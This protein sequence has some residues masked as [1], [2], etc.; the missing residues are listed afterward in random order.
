MGFR[1]LMRTSSVVSL[2]CVAATLPAPAFAQQAA[3]RAQGAAADVEQLRAE[4]ADARAQIAAQNQKL[5]EQQRRL[6]LFE[7]RLQGLAQTT[8][9]IR[10]EALAAG[11]SAPSGSVSG[12]PAPTTRVG[13]PPKDSDRPPAVA[14]LDQQG[15]AV[16]R[17]GELIAEFGLDYTRAD[18]NR[19]VFR[20]VNF[21]ETVLVGAFDINESRQDIVTESVAVRYGLFDRFDIGARA[22]LIYRSDKLITTP[23]AGSTNNDPARSIDSAAT[24]K[25][26]GDLELS[27]RYQI[28]KGGRGRPFFTANLQ[29]VIPTGRD[30]FSVPRDELGTPLKAA[31]G[32]GFY[33]I[34]PSITAILPSEPAVL[35]GTIGYTLNMAK[36]INTRIPPAQIDRIDPGDQVTFAAGIGISL[37]DRTSMNFGY[38]HAWVFGTKTTS[39]EYNTTTGEIIGAP[40]TKTSRNLQV[41][42]LLIGVSHKFTDKLQVNWSFE[43]GATDDAPDVRTSL[44]IPIRF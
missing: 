41:G 22:S 42:R 14:V 28:N 36:N 35:F 44:R 43:V 10:N 7:Q 24:G 3:E 30:P 1:E 19:A 32:A 12:T 33:S 11:P 26:I 40:V 16:T 31:T 29:G 34:A 8:Q 15:S 18:R 39:R 25:G 17:K 5:A 38:S 13:E 37:N 6:D 27:V 2:A 23:I 4:L 20:G 9:Q 21:L